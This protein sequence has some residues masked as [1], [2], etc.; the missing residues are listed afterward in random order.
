VQISNT[1]DIT[2]VTINETPTKDI[3]MN[4]NSTTTTIDEVATTTTTTT[5]TKTTTT[6][7]TTEADSDVDVVGDVAYVRRIPISPPHGLVDACSVLVG[8]FCVFVTLSLT[9]AE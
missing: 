9:A 1:D 5:T 8:M 7:P 2:F 3:D 6:T 4:N